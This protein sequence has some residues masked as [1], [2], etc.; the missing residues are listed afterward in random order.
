MSL[1]YI[2]FL[3]FGII[4]DNIKSIISN[5]HHRLVYIK[6]EVN[7]LIFYDSNLQQEDIIN[8]DDTNDDDDDVVIYF[9]KKENGEFLTSFN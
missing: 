8:K 2:L 1:K 3:F 4:T 9:K 5:M 7:I 6:F